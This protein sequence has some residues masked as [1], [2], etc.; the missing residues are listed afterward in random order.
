MVFVWMH[1]GNE[2]T[3][4]ANA[5]AHILP[6][7]PVHHLLKDNLPKLNWICIMEMNR[8][9]LHF[10]QLRWAAFGEDLQLSKIFKAVL[11]NRLFRSSQRQEIPTI[12][13]LRTLTGNALSFVVWW[14]EIARVLR[15]H[16]FRRSLQCRLE[17]NQQKPSMQQAVFWRPDPFNKLLCFQVQQRPKKSHHQ[18][19]FSGKTVLGFLKVMLGENILWCLRNTRCLRLHA[20]TFFLLASFLPSLV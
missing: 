9:F 19:L 18:V 11:I 14:G 3:I 17:I 7:S 8:Q 5:H 2:S 15:T 20:H 1:H 4:F 10:H 13:Q 12:F 16:P 6:C